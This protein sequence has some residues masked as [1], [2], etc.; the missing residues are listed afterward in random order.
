M[1]IIVVIA[2]VVKHL[3]VLYVRMC[4]DFWREGTITADIPPLQNATIISCSLK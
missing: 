3:N 4:R 1:M 2:F